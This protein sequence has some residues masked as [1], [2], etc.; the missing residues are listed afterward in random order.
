[1]Q[2]LDGDLD[3]AFTSVGE[4]LDLLEPIGGGRDLAMACSQRSAL[5]MFICDNAGSISWGQRALALAE[6]CGALDV[7]SHAL[8]NIGTSEWCFGREHGRELLLR[9]LELAL[10]V[11]AVEHVGRAYAN[12]A[13]QATLR[14]RPADA[15]R[16]I[17]DGLS[18]SRSR[19]LSRSRICL[20]SGMA[21]VD[22]VEGRYD[23]AAANVRLPAQRADLDGDA[24]RRAHR[25]G[26]SPR[27][28]WRSW[29]L[30]ADRRGDRA[31]PEVR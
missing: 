17:E 18:Y 5:A 19:G 16:Y 21:A 15:R 27:P 26:S 12:L 8:N 14:M 11:D 9:S 7:Q 13:E 31:R 23:A 4:A 25:V 20:E 2:W 10:Q 3:G 1:M 22:L 6:A 29:G 28:P 30:E 24:Y